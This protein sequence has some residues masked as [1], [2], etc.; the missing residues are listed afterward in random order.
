MIIIIKAKLTRK[1]LT[2]IAAMVNDLLSSC[3]KAKFLAD[4]GIYITEEKKYH[5]VCTH[6]VKIRMFETYRIKGILSPFIKVKSAV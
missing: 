1:M 3:S 2:D 5:I 4:K 6:W